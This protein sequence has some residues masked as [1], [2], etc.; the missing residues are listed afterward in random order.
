MEQLPGLLLAV[1]VLLGIVGTAV[2][3]MPGPVLVGG[4]AIAYALW[5]QQ[6]PITIAAA[7]AVV[8][9]LFGFALKYAV[10]ARKVGGQVDALPLVI[11][12]ILGLIGFFVV[13]V[14]G[15]IL[16]FILGVFLTEVA[17]KRSFAEA[18]PA[19]RSALYAAGLSM[20]IDLAATIVA[21]G[22]I[23]AAAVIY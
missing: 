7:I 10:P 19:T 9:L 21:G 13:P 2:P 20:L 23:L 14:V 8:V 3:L 1:A 6:T 16:G 11:G 12:G 4:A 15:L 18:V 22:I 5:A 17:Q